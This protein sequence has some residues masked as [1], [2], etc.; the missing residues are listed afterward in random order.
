MKK[1]ITITTLLA[2]G[3]L[4]ASAETKTAYI[5]FGTKAEKSTGALEVAQTKN[6]ATIAETTLISGLL[7]VSGRITN[8][9]EV[10]NTNYLLSSLSTEASKYFGGVDSKVWSDELNAHDNN[11]ENTMSLTFSSLAA[12][13]TYTVA[14][15]SGI[16]AVGSPGYFPA[17]YGLKLSLGSETISGLSY[18]EDATTGTAFS[19]Y[20]GSG[21]MKETQSLFVWE[22]TTGADI[23]SD[24]SF[25]LEAT[26][27]TY[28]ALAIVV[29]TI[30]EP[31]AFGLL[32]GL[33]AL[34]LAGTRRRRRK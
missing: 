21:N 9:G 27:G 22:F 3:T 2:A 5:D 19:T 30:P 17:C 16:G 7:S 6:E 11:S 20:N 34:A 8:A 28:N 31:S 29:S 1:L 12:N 13:T 32:A 18:V 23:A 4:F 26:K 14:L 10:A 33:G 15:L 24:L 25:K